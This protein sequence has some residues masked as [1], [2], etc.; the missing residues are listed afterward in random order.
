MSATGWLRLVGSL[1]LQVSFAEYS[2]FDRALL[3]K[4][5]IILRSLPFVATP[6]LEDISPNTPNQTGVATNGRLLKMIGLFC[7][8]ALSKKLYFAKETC[9]LRSLQEVLVQV[10]VIFGRYQS[11]HT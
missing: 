10:G 8:R 5:P 6:Y 3:Q 1:K 2:F 11:K 4:R 9:N 7:K